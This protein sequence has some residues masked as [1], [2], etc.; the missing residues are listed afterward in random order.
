MTRSRCPTD[1]DYADD[2]SLL[3]STQAAAKLGVSCK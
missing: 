3:T 1:A 2:L